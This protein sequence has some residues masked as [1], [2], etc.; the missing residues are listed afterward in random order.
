MNY[1]SHMLT[2]TSFKGSSIARRFAQ[3]YPVVVLARNPANYTDVV[4][5]INSAGGLAIG[6][7][8]DVSDADSVSQT[9]KKITRELFPGS[10]I[11][12]AVFNSGGGFVRKP[13]LELTQAEFS[14]GWNGQVNGAFLFAQAALPLLL[15]GVEEKIECPPTLIFTGMMIPFHLSLQSMLARINQVDSNGRGGETKRCN[16]KCSGFSKFQH[17]CNCQIRFEGAHSVAGERIRSQG[18][19]YQPCHCGWCD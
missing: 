18:R 11:A 2:K 10:P 6:L 19:T 7:S 9:F 4:D 13:F 5:S 3:H 17:I 8:T 12:A 14:S 15:K 16:G 1:G